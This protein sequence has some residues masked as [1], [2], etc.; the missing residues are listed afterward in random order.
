MRCF[1]G[2]FWL[3]AFCVLFLAW[4]VLAARLTAARRQSE[5]GAARRPVISTNS[6]TQRPPRDGNTPG[7]QLDIDPRS[8]ITHR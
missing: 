8:D 6:H 3:G 5:N 7:R 1:L 2:V 4:A